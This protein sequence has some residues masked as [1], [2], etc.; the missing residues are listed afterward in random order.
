MLSISNNPFNPKAS[1][2]TVEENK[3]SLVSSELASLTEQLEKEGIDL[4]FNTK[5]LNYLSPN[6]K[7][8]SLAE[9]K[10]TF[11]QEIQKCISEYRSANPSITSIHLNVENGKI[12]AD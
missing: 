1:S 10:E 12:V 11:K 2:L 8:S 6:Q 4:S 9:L 7:N 5:I 3:Q